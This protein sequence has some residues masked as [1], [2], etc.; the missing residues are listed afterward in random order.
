MKKLYALSFTALLLISGK[1][2]S[3]FTY[4]PTDTI[5][6]GAI[7]NDLLCFAKLINNTSSAITLRVTREQNV[8]ADA[9]NWYSAFCIEACYLPA[10]DSINYTLLPDTTVNFSFHFYTLNETLPDSAT[11]VMK[12][13][14]TG[15]P[16]NT[17]YQKFYGITQTGFS[18]N[19]ISAVSAAVSIYPMPVAAR[20]VFSMNISNVKT[21]KPLSLVVCNMFGNVVSTSNVIAGINFMNLDLP[22]GIYSYSLI[23]ARANLHSGKLAVSR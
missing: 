5:R 12:W 9:P 7:G 11:A 21:S 16:S 17:F 2:F 22:A 10:V 23:S 20:N 14:N 19:D 15:N 18:V 1:S 3:Q 8:M 6:Y 13:K 4:T